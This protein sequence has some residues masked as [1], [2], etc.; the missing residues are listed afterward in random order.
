MNKSW[1]NKS[2]VNK[3]S[4][5]AWLQAVPSHHEKRRALVLRVEF[6]VRD[7]ATFSSVQIISL[8]L[9]SLARA[10]PAA[11]PQNSPEERTT[12]HP[13]PTKSHSAC[14]PE[15]PCSAGSRRN[16][17]PTTGAFRR[18]GQ[19]PDTRRFGASLL[20]RSSR[21]HALRRSDAGARKKLHTFRTVSL[22]YCRPDCVSLTAQY[23]PAPH[24]AAAPCAWVPK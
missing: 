9:R 24:G 21:H 8:I 13:P 20:Y 22:A 14:H 17:P 11:V 15:S 3:V 12:D 7:T 18:R 23:R 4:G 1:V 19:S 5:R 10:F 16:A 2:W 6:F